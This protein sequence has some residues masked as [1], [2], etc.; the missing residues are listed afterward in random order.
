VLP[1]SE[2]SGN[3]GSRAVILGILSPL[4]SLFPANPAICDPKLNPTRWTFLIGTSPLWS[5]TSRN[6]LN[7]SATILTFLTAGR[8]HGNVD[9]SDQSSRI[10]LKLSLR[11]RYAAKSAFTIGLTCSCWSTFGDAAAALA[12]RRLCESVYVNNGG[13]GRI[14]SGP[15]RRPWSVRFDNCA[16]IGPGFGVEHETD[17]DSRFDRTTVRTEASGGEAHFHLVFTWNRQ[18]FN[19][20]SCCQRIFNYCKVHV[21]ALN[22]RMKINKIKYCLGEILW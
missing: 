17:V 10:T 5:N 20:V 14:D 4:L 13:G 7:L 12:R 21:G 19:L 16:L 1:L 15:P 8:Y 22:E 6:F 3:A 18:R 2:Y 9:N 11:L